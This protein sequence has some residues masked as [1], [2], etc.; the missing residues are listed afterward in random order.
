LGILQ[1]IALRIEKGKKLDIP[2]KKEANLLQEIISHISSEENLDK[3][4]KQR[5]N[6][7]IKEWIQFMTHDMDHNQNFLNQQQLENTLNTFPQDNITENKEIN[8]KRN[9]AFL[10][11]KN[12]LKE[13]ITSPLKNM[14]IREEPKKVTS[15]IVTPENIPMFVWLNQWEYREIS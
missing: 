3:I 13:I 14:K 15:I 1:R 10:K 6:S 9:T 5:E 12:A 11:Y 2:D 8:K 7:A 4:L